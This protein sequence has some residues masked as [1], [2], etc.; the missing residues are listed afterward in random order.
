MIV[1]RETD[2]KIR[3]GDQLLDATLA[4][5]EIIYQTGAIEP[6]V[7]ANYLESIGEHFKIKNAAKFAVELVN[8]YQPTV[9]EMK[10]QWYKNLYTLA[11]LNLLHFNYL[12]RYCKIS[13]EKADRLYTDRATWRK[14][15]PKSW[16]VDI[17]QYDYYLPSL[18][19]T[20]DEIEQAQYIRRL[21]VLDLLAVRKLLES[22][23]L[24]VTVLL[25]ILKM[26][27]P[28][29]DL[30]DK[31]YLIHIGQAIVDVEINENH[32]SFWLNRSR[33]TYDFAW[34]A[35]I[36]IGGK[37]NFNL[38]AVLARLDQLRTPGMNL[39]L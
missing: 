6:R 38:D 20:P 11:E 15:F 17:L 7:A 25:K 37:D 14:L 9:L 27:C 26:L 2:G 1:T 24:L 31:I 30:W 16:S 21:K 33:F 36:L 22:N 32:A 39:L 4:R 28:Y 10:Y 8:H 3:L 35:K 29:K 34:L 13:S 5:K 19:G 18:I 12:V 23:S